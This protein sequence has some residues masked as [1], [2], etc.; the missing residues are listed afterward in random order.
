MPSLTSIFIGIIAALLLAL[1]VGGWVLKG[2]IERRAVAE[3]ALTIA[4]KVNADNV[5]ALAA[6]K[7]EAAQERDR[8]IAR[9]RERDGMAASVATLR[10]A[11]GDSLGACRWTDEQAKA[12][13]DFGVRP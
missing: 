9:Q 13:D 12:L 8:A 11:L 5:A 10:Q 1:G 2:Q 7:I 6:A 4:V 3:Q